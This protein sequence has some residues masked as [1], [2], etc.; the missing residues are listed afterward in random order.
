[1]INDVNTPPTHPHTH[2]LRAS[3]R[4]PL[5]YVSPSL[6]PSCLLLLYLYCADC[7]HKAQVWFADDTYA[8]VAEATSIK[9]ILPQSQNA[10]L[11]ITS[12]YCRGTPP[13]FWATPNFLDS[14][15]YLS[16]EVSLLSESMCIFSRKLG[17]SKIMIFVP[18]HCQLI[19]PSR[20]ILECEFSQE[21]VW[22]LIYGNDTNS[23][24]RE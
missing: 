21:W 9:S 11:L 14:F 7:E 17:K 8:P 18:C 22:R 16:P 24:F 6:P 2:T 15:H 19:P 23:I 20:K 12:P 4:F 1:M 13:G 3:H 5:E 10:L